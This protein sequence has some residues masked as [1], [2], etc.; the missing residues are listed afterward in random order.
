MN[1]GLSLENGI[2]I[3][4]VLVLLYLF[5]DIKMIKEEKYT[6]F[7]ADYQME[8]GKKEFIKK[9]K[10]EDIKQEKGDLMVD[11]EK[12]PEMPIVLTDF[13]S[14]PNRRDIMYIE[15]KEEEVKDPWQITQESQ[16][17][18]GD[19]LDGVPDIYKQ[20]DRTLPY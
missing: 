1:L 11:K 9:M 8:H 10:M 15:Q 4:F 6:D 16:G 18:L 3:V 7:S 13:H 5:Y 14:T 19:N 12:E 2:V 17:W 20:V